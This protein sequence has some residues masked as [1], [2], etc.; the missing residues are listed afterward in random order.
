MNAFKNLIHISWVVGKNRTT[1][2]SSPWYG[3]L[4]CF[5][6]QYGDCQKKLDMDSTMSSLAEETKVEQLWKAIGPPSC[7]NRC[8]K[9]QR[10]PNLMHM[11]NW[12]TW[13]EWGTTENAVEK[14]P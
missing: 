7:V 10:S 13:S 9:N 6:A 3:H 4:L 5:I 8:K 11:S 14:F 2:Y 1:H 12:K